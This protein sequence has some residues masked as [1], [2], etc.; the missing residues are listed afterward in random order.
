MKNLES[1]PLAFFQIFLIFL[2]NIFFFLS[3]VHPNAPNNNPNPADLFFQE[4]MMAVPPGPRQR[5]DA[6]P[7][8]QGAQARADRARHFERLMRFNH[9]QI[10]GGPVRPAQQQ[11]QQD[12]N[13]ETGGGGRRRA[14]QVCKFL[15]VID[16]V[17]VIRS[18][19]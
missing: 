15:P 6:Y 4:Y 17:L 3:V 8:A 2:K 7:P 12:D 18:E 11:P 9:E 5:L 13:N 16:N 14:P 1:N 10:N 19:W